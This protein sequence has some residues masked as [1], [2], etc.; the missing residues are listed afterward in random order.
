MIQ[1]EAR[2]EGAITLPPNRS[3]P[4][5]SGAV[6]T[7]REPSTPNGKRHKNVI[8]ADSLAQVK[9]RR[10]QIETTRR[11]TK[12]GAYVFEYSRPFQKKM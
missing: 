7:Q 5:P 9:H 4:H 8:A 10:C 1:I 12:E 3:R 2:C 6:H 11:L